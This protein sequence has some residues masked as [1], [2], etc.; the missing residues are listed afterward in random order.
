ME[1]NE[2]GDFTYLLEQ[3]ADI[4]IMAYPVPGID[5]LSIDQKKLVYFLSQAAL[6]GRDIIFDQNYKH[7]LRIRKTLEAIHNSYTG[8]RQTD[9]FKQ[10]VIYLKRVWFSNGIHHHYST[11][12][13]KPGFSEPYFFELV[14]KSSGAVFPLNSGQDISMFIDEMTAIL[15]DPEIAPKRVSLDSD[16]DL[17]TA[18]ACNFYEGVTQEQ[19]E[20]FYAALKDPSDEKPVSFGLNSRLVQVNGDV[21]E[22]VYRVGGLYSKALEKIIMWLEKALDVAENDIQRATIQKLIDFYRS[23]NLK[24]FDEYNVLWVGD[25]ISQVDFVSGF[26]EVYGDPLGMKATWESVV[27]FKDVEATKRTEIISANAQWFEDHSPIDDR[28]KK[29]EVKGV[30]AKVITVAQLGGDCY[31][32]TPIG[33]NLPNADWIRKEYGSKSVSYTHLRAHET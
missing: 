17:I 31:P 10:F 23:G 22:E 2:Q 12:K 20:S 18:S 15:F 21:R 30:S 25:L 19:A 13:I 11:D 24:A 6:C 26:I 33:I 3:F 32:S 9:D 8:D 29:R 27:N 14:R 7:N 16:N 4:K 28:F 1:N 5:S